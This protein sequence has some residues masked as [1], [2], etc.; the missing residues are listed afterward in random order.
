M[1]EPASP[2]EILDRKLERCIAGVPEEVI[3]SD[4]ANRSPSEAVRRDHVD[5]EAE[6]GSSKTGLDCHTC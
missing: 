4:Q 5:R 1:V 6:S 3:T 2:F